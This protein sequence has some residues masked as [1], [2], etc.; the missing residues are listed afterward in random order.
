MERVVVRPGTPCDPTAVAL[1]HAAGHAADRVVHPDG[2]LRIV[3]VRQQDP[4]AARIYPGRDVRAW[5]DIDDLLFAVA[6]YPH[7]R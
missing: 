7:R 3:E 4:P 1:T 6:R 5:L 2:T